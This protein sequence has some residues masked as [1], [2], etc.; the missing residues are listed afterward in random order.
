MAVA[1][2]RYGVFCD[3]SRTTAF[4]TLLIPNFA[5]DNAKTCRRCSMNRLVTLGAIIT[6]LC[7]I[8]ATTAVVAKDARSIAMGGAVIANGKGAHGVLSNPASMMQM[9]RRGETTHILLGF[10]GEARADSELVDTL[11]DEANETI[12]DDL[13]DEIENLNSQ[14]ITCNPFTATDDTVCIADTDP[15]SVLADR[16]LNILDVLE[17]ETVD[18]HLQT[19][20]GIAF[21]RGDTPYSINLGVSGTFSGT[22]TI[23][24]GDRVYVGQF[25]DVLEGDLTFG[26]VNNEDEPDFITFDGTA[27]TVDV[28]LP[29]AIDPATGLPVLN[30]SGQAA[31]LIRVQLGVS[32]AR[33]LTVAGYQVDM[34]ITPKISSLRAADVSTSVQEEL[35][36]TARSIQ[37]RFDD[38]ENTE[39]SF[40]VDLGF[41]TKLPTLPIQV[42]AV[43]RNLI[44]ESIETENDFE[45]ETTPQVTVG[46]A[47]QRGK[48]NVTG[49]LALNSAKVDNFETQKIGVG[50][51]YGTRK[52][53]IRAGIAYDVDRDEDATAFTLGFGLGPLQ[54]G[55][56]L[57]EV[58]STELS[59][60]LSYSFK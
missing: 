49:D 58:E 34:G 19:D 9:H 32:L 52:Y 17:G 51:E 10:S 44:P 41:S 28:V 14:N 26:E 29:D 3:V 46:A 45:F 54:V 27:G 60:Q 12:F 15:I 25:A 23:P 5:C 50:I 16:I 13:E 48:L 6:A 24:E 2:S 56:R 57:S 35:N 31:A 8:S 39:S 40:T 4:D 21:T 36:D 38:S 59:A 11:T 30:S 53:A 42:A 43:V 1:V 20:L 47:Y 33:T 37:D 55:A 22:S 7:S 18:G